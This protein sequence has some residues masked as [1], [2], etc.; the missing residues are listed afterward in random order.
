MHIHFP[1]APYRSLPGPSGTSVRA[2]LYH[3]IIYCKTVSRPLLWVGQLKAMLDLR[4]LWDDSSPCLVACSGGLRYV[5]LQASVIHH[6]PVVAHSDMHVLLEAIHVFTEIGLLWNARQWAKKLRRKLSLFQGGSPTTTLPEDHADFTSTTT[7]QIEEV[8]TTADNGSQDQPLLVSS[9]SG[10]HFEDTSV[11]IAVLDPLNN[12]STSLTLQ[13]SEGKSATNFDSV[14]KPETLPSSTTPAYHFPSSTAPSASG[15]LAIDSSSCLSPELPQVFALPLGLFVSMMRLCKPSTMTSR[16]SLSTLCQNPGRAPTWS[17]PNLRQEVGS[18]GGLAST[19]ATWRFP[20]VVDAIVKLA[21][22]RPDG[23]KSEPFLSAQLNVAT[24]LPIHKDKNNVG[25]SWLIALGNF[26]GG[27]LWVESPVGLEPPPFPA[28]AWQKKLRG[29]VEQVTKGERRS[30]ALF[31]P[32]R[33]KKLSPQCIDELS[34]VGFNPP[35][36]AQVAIASANAL[37]ALVSSQPLPPLAALAPAQ[38]PLLEE[39]FMPFLCN[40]YDADHD[41][42]NDTYTSRR[43][44]AGCS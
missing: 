34:E 31:S 7:V 6:L 26:E 17:L 30:I 13:E 3:N 33:L 36:S 35:I 11:K 16:S 1:P 29:G 28:A 18:L 5:L 15:Q 44:R 19:H 4:F 27:R 8:T 41:T 23:F 14:S 12:S 40:D 43:R 2:L 20:E 25:R 39:A 10:Y 21:S 42:S 37:P 22:T 38:G 32:K 24:S 9:S